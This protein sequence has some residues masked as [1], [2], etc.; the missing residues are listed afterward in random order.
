MLR[1]AVFKSWYWSKPLI[2]KRKSGDSYNINEL[3]IYW[4]GLPAS[5]LYIN[6]SYSTTVNLFLMKGKKKAPSTACIYLGRISWNGQYGS[7][8]F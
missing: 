4:P 8:E 1:T 3:Y 2:K 5:W 6:Q 7:E